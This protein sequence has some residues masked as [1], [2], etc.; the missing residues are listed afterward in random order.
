MSG[1][2]TA[3]A[4][5]PR[6]APAPRL[7]QPVEAIA[8]DLDGT[9]VDSAPDIRHAL[10][11]A[12]HKAGLRSFD[13]PTVRGWIGDGPDATIARALVAQAIDP[14]NAAGRQLCDHLRRSFDMTALA[15][16]MSLGHVF[17][18]V[19]EMLA[20][21]ARQVPCVVVT[22]KPTPLARALLNAAH[23]LP[24]LMAVFGADEPAQRKPSPVL[25]QAAADHLGVATAALLMVG[26]GRADLQAAASAGCPAVLA[27]WGYGATGWE[28]PPPWR[29]DSPAELPVQLAACL[30]STLG[31]A[32]PVNTLLHF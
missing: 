3:T 6:P 29:M 17:D 5:V 7:L 8:F 27:D 10:N 12:L 30:K 24:H 18:G 20:A 19:P 1:T 25:L 13:L 4:A 2:P 28:G 32:G 16:P 22:N 21:L 31:P 11:S 9:L 26:D 14:T 23:L 15:A